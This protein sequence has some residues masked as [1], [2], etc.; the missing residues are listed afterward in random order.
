MYKISI[1]IN[2]PVSLRKSG[3]YTGICRLKTTPMGSLPGGR[4][5]FDLVVKFNLK[6]IFFQLILSDNVIILVCKT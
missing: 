4:C 2:Y 5:S 6:L 1:T 3:G